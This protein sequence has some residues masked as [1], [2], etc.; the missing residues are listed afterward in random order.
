MRTQRPR[1]QRRHQP[2]PV[3][4]LTL[5]TLVAG[6]GLLSAPPAAAE[7]YIVTMNDGA[8]FE[9]RYQP[10]EASW[11]PGVVMLLTEYGNWIAL[12]RADMADV[13]TDVESRGFGKV[14]DT[15]TISLGILAN[16]AIPPEEQEQPDSFQQLQQ[17]L[18]QQNQQR[19][20]YTVNQ[21]AEPSEVQGGLPVGFSQQQ[22]APILVNQ[23][24]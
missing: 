4:V 19:Q 11:D 8:V 16:D 18:S 22:N 13:T 5:A 17:F 21:F 20:D 15:N 12:Q 7:T 14:I 23:P 9:S 10:E 3:L 2:R 1:Q 24:Q 6:W